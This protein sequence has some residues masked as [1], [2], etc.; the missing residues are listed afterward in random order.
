MSKVII[1]KSKLD[2]L[3]DA[4]ASVSGAQTPLTLDDVVTEVS[5]LTKVEGTIT[6]NVNGSIDVTQYAE[7][8]VDVPT[9]TPTLQDKTISIT[10]TTSAQTQTV[11][12]DAGYDGLDEVTINTAAAPPSVDVEALSVTE[13]GTYSAPSGK[14]YSPVT[15]NVSGGGG[16]TAD[17]IAMRTISG[18]MSGSA[19]HIPASAFQSCAGITAASFPNA[20]FVGSYAF[21]RTGISTAY[22]PIANS[23]SGSAFNDCG[24]LASAAFP[25][26]TS[27]AGS[28]FYDCK[29]LS[30][31]N[32]SKLVN[33]GQYA[34]YHCERLSAVELPMVSSIPTNAFQWCS[35]LSVA[36]FQ[37]ASAIGSYAF[38]SCSRLMSLYML[39]TSVARLVSRTAFSSTP[40]ALSTYAGGWG[41]IFVPASLV[42]SYKTASG[43]S[44]YASRIT[45]YEG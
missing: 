43:W 25:N 30:E 3:A 31:I 39:S 45:S 14:A 32:F 35:A 29:N 9:P 19:T 42:D 36:S 8:E 5:G 33:L 21:M 4:V 18:V 44:V 11:T 28:A 41:S 34:F 1:S 15:V 27:I 24:S 10:P 13:N 38:A 23:V 12:A 20:S 6:I 40:F 7:A 22:F 16:I 2:S 26:V 17:D 37:K